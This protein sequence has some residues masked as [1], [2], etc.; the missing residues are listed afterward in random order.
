[1]R[2]LVT[3]AAGRVGSTLVVR[4]AAAGHDVRAMVRPGGRKPHPSVVSVADVVEAALDDA[5]AL[6]S[7]VEGAEVIV[8][9]A[10]TMVVGD[11]APERLFDTNTAGTLRLLEAAADAGAVRRFVLAS[12]DNTYGP[13]AP[14]YTPITEDH[15]QRPGDYY[16]TS[17]LLAEHLVRNLAVM[18]GMEYTIMRL[19]SVVAPDEIGSLFR[20]S[21]AQAFLRGQ[22]AAGRR[23]S[24]WPL[25]DGRDDLVAAVDAAAAGRDDDPAAVLTGDGQPW[26]VHLTDVRD[27][28]AGL[29]LG[30]GEAAAAGGEFNVVGPRTTSFD[31]AASVVA[32]RLGLPVVTVDLPVRLAFEVS[33]AEAVRVLGFAPRWDFAGMLD[34]ALSGQTPDDYV[35]VTAS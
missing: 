34:T 19:G 4:L 8:H 27:A 28:V 23:G 22:V 33:A 17:K 5:A 30:I 26:A 31:E 20:L 13:A 21:W 12:T 16:G 10:A 11:D 18:H 32:D 2:I 25:F 35:P 1:M 9:L 7:A 24:L 3:G 15:P 14:V 29:L 6:R